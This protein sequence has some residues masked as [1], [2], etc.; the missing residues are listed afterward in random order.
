MKFD[1]IVVNVIS[2]SDPRY[3]VFTCG[4]ATFS[5]SLMLLSTLLWFKFSKVVPYMLIF[6]MFSLIF[7]QLIF[8]CLKLNISLKA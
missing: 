7:S 2:P 3:S 8:H 4:C 6:Y 5:V 1:V